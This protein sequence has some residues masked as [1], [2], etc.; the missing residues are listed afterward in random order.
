MSEILLPRAF[1]YSSGQ[2]Q[3]HTA[4][5]GMWLFLASEM[6]FFG[7]L[8]LSWIFCRHW[9]PV[10]FD[11]GARQTA[12]ALGTINTVLLV[13]SSVTYTAGAQYIEAGNA[14]GLVWSCILTGVLGLA[15]MGIKFGLEW[16]D[17]FTR[18]L[19][20]GN[21]FAI[22]GAA[23]AGAQM[24]FVFYFVATALHGVHMLVGIG[25][26]VWITWRA[27]R[28]EFSAAYSTPVAVVGLYWSFVD[29]VWIVL[30]PLIYL[31]GRAPG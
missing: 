14:R 7:V 10:G 12:L 24:F 6:L 21:D 1:Q 18:H 29:M 20:P 27:R 11:V 4:I 3:A 23:R 22:Y 15:F 19:F 2:H 9:N 25:L 28:G 13:T 16:H 8:F 31:V 30:Y 5:S 17:D 26:L